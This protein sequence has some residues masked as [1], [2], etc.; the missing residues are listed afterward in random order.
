MLEKRQTESPEKEV[1]EP[2]NDQDIVYAFYLHEVL[3]CHGVQ[4]TVPTRNGRFLECQSQQR[5]RALDL[6][7]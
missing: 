6:W 1:G 3:I 7:T 5:P 4:R 2:H